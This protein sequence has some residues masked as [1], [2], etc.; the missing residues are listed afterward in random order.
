MWSVNY[1][2]DIPNF[3]ANI[4]LSVSAYLVCS[5]VT[6]LPHSGYFLV[7]STCLRISRSHCF[8]SANQI[9]SVAMISSD[10]QRVHMVGLMAS[11]A[12]VAEDDLVSHQWKGEALGS[13]TALCPSV[14]NARARKQEWVG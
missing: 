4:Y 13:V 12:Y 7:L 9:L 3:W 11:A 5:F 2:L 14:G 1:V 6:G 8:L 10:Y